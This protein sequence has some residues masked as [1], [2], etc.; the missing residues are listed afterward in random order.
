MLLPTLARRSHIVLLLAVGP[1]PAFLLG[2]AFLNERGALRRSAMDRLLDVSAS[3]ARILAEAP[4]R[5]RARPPAGGGHR[6][7]AALHPAGGDDRDGQW[8][9]FGRHAAGSAV[10]ERVLEGLV[11]APAA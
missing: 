8:L 7:A 10:L 5:P 1:T 11:R 6:A 3:G 4:L 2:G 9:R